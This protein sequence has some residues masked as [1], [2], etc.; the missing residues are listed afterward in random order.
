MKFFM[1]RGATV[2][3]Y[4]EQ[5]LHCTGIL[6]ICVLIGGSCFAAYILHFGSNVLI[7]NM[8]PLMCVLHAGSPCQLY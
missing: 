8:L 1:L 2:L 3:R 4:K 7:R 6:C 5:S